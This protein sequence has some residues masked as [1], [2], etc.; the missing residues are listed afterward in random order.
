[1]DIAV[2]SIVVVFGIYLVW[3]LMPRNKKKNYR[4]K[5]FSSSRHRKNKSE[6]EA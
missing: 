5:R 2:I 1:M 6:K 4:S 3:K